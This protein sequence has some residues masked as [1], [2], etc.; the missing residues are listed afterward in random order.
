[1]RDT[2]LRMPPGTE[3]TVIDARVFSRKGVVKDDRALKIEEEERKR[4][5][6]DRADELRIIRQGAL[7]QLSALL[8]GKET[9]TRLTDDTRKVLIGKGEVDHAREARRDS[10]ELLGRDQGRR[11]QGRGR[12]CRASSMR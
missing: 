2:S 5:E 3:G 8:L 9:M 6:A 12:S 1:M 11:R 4:L 10:V 7:A